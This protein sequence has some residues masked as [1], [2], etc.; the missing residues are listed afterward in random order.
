MTDFVMPSLGADMEAGTLVE[1]MVRPGDQVKRGDVV[2]VVETQKGAIEI[3][4]FSSGTVSEIV[5]PVGAKVPV[6]TVL[7]RLDGPAIVAPPSATAP[8]PAPP[9]PQAAPA[10]PV[11]STAPPPMA[12]VPPFGTA[13]RASPAA[14]HLA[15]QRGVDLSALAGSGPGGAIILSDVQAATAPAERPA[16]RRTGFDAAA[17]RQAI[18]AAMSRSKREI[19]HYYVS[20]TIDVSGALMQLDRINEGRPPTTRLLPAVLF[21]RAVAQALRKSPE[22]NGYWDGDA[23]RPVE[24]IHVGWAVALR[25]GGLVAPAIH[26]ADRLPLDGL[27]AALRD[28][29][30][31][32]RG[33]GLR[34]SEMTDATI[35]I[36]SLGERG[37]ETVWPV[38]YPP[39]V[40]IVGVGRIVTRPWVVGDTVVPRPVATLTLAADHRASD[41]HR[42]GLFLAEI[43]R[44]LQEPIAS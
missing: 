43:E 21:L 11:P 32:A 15:A 35:T 1:W 22:L 14:R 2:A 27:M 30:T 34:S 3:E 10:M 28:L 7:A 29:V 4:I 19:P 5:V 31:R 38:I 13:L 12:A 33:G 20:Q 6:G 23:F 17:M 8:P 36:T 9:P 18:G 44:L 41:G 25:G 42:G 26:D 24:A 40:A 39:Q 16:R 37:A